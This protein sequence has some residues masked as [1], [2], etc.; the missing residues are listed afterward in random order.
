MGWE[1]PLEEDMAT[2]SNVLACRISWTE[3][4]WGHKELGMT[5]ELSTYLK[6]LMEKF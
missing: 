6:T 4:P 2:H 1:E 3:K 5:E